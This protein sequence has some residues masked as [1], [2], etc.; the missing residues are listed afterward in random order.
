MIFGDFTCDADFK[1][2]DIR[3]SRVPASDPDLDDGIDDFAPADL[4]RQPTKQNTLFFRIDLRH[5]E[6]QPRM[7]ISPPTELSEINGVVCDERI[8]AAAH[9]RHQ[10]PI[11]PSRKAR[12]SYMVCLVAA[13]VGNRNQAWFIDASE[14][15]LRSSRGLRFPETAGQKPGCS[16][17]G[18]APQSRLETG[19]SKS[20]TVQ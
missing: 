11:R 16:P 13:S 7:E 6:N 8:I 19:T 12:V 3:S 20:G 15:P 4:T 1:G 10:F 5:D 9:A 14:G 2:E 17:E 18:L